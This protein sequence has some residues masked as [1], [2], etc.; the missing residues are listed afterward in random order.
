MTQIPKIPQS[1]IARLRAGVPGESGTMGAP[2][3]DANL[4]SAFSENSLEKRER[5][6]VMEHL[7]GCPQCRDV[8]ALQALAATQVGEEGSPSKTPS[9]ARGWLS[10]TELR[11]AAVAASLAVVAAIVLLRPPDRV[12]QERAPSLSATAPPQSPQVGK[13]QG[14]ASAEKKEAPTENKVETAKQDK[15]RKDAV[16]EDEIARRAPARAAVAKT[17]PMPAPAVTAAIANG[18]FDREVLKDRAA[19]AAPPAMA[20]E[21]D[22]TGALAPS[23]PTLPANSYDSVTANQSP[24]P[25]AAPS[26]AQGAARA[27]DVRDR[28]SEMQT[29]NAIT[30]SAA[31]ETVTTQEATGTRESGAIAGA[32]GYGSLRKLPTHVPPPGERWRVEQGMLQL[33]ENAGQ[34]WSTVAPGTVPVPPGLTVLRLGQ[35]IWAGDSQGGLSHS[36]D[37]GVHWQRV[38]YG[39]RENI[40]GATIVSIL[41]PNP[42]QMIIRN[43]AG[44]SWV[45]RDGG[46]TWRTK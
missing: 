25:G 5:A 30:T 6:E 3:P 39:G 43:S 24:L 33:S 36:L 13:M 1:V 34:T 23:A 15:K 41:V 8:L 4:L 28:K 42:G 12:D 22:S 38:L 35:E 37:N 18:N 17:A 27:A 10:R 16:A 14:K 45:S 11:W 2:H 9:H 19:A 26:G 31:A 7:A 20:K 21:K 29:A 46:E 44:V 32:I 40:A